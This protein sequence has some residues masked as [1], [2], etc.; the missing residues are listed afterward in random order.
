[1]A[2]ADKDVFGVAVRGALAVKA[3]AEAAVRATSNPE[4]FMV[5]I[6]YIDVGKRLLVIIVCSNKELSDVLKMHSEYIEK[7]TDTVTF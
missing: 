4:N 6:G 7:N 2:V 1:M 5:Y 3:L